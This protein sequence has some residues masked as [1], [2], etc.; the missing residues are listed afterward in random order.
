[1]V[2][3]GRIVWVALLVV[4]MAVAMGGCSSAGTKKLTPKVAPPAVAE[5]GT[6]R[7][8]VDLSVPPFGGAV[9]KRRAGL[10]VD[11]AAAL[12]KKLGLKLE[13]VD[14]APSEA[15]TALAEGDVDVVL[16]LPVSGASTGVSLAGTYIDDAPA[17]F[18]VAAE[19]ASVD[20]SLTL[21]TLRAEKVGVQERSSA[22][23]TLRS[24]LG[25]ESVVA[26]ATLRDALVALD[27][28]Q[29]P[30]VAGDAL[31]GAYI[32][33]DMPGIQFAGQLEDASPLS[34]GVEAANTELAEAVRVALDEIAVDGAFDT[35]RH[36]WL[37]SFPTLHTAAS[38]EATPAP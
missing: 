38:T 22:Y 25:S 5:K 19:G 9:G 20:A 23:W 34:V 7:A 35:I 27:E 14:V 10:D 37:G 4:V 29:I 2:R 18:S 15:A 33:R 31:V 13:I 8:G 11:V 30:L 26:F 21:D 16:S 28:G 32:I 24:E 6:L 3:S 12:A 1:M 17:F 36:K